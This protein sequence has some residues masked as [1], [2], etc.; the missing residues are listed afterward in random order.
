VACALA[1]ALACAAPGA[2]AQAPATQ[3][4]VADLSSREIAITTGFA[5]ADLLL[6]GAVEGRGDVV[7]VVRGPRRAIVVREKSQVAGVWINTHSR[8]FVG[9]PVYY[10]AAA[11]RPLDEVARRAI[12]AQY[13]IGEEHMSFPLA[14]GEPEEG[15]EPFR[16]AL[17]RNKARMGLYAGALGTVSVIDRR[18]FRTTVSFPAN[19]P[20]GL[21][22]VEMYLFRDGR[23]VTRRTTPLIVRKV[24]VEAQIFDYAHD[25]AA[26]YGSIAIV[27]AL[28]AGWAAGA[29]FR[30]A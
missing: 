19:V 25:H 4:L 17:L 3:P 12:L 16:E 14:A 29:V 9:V 7:V 2:F 15:A 21:Y 5:G 27:V 11:T 22:G 28:V 1:G 30:R 8:A 24:G 10:R 20:T 13:E 23:I 6:F 18:L 26:I